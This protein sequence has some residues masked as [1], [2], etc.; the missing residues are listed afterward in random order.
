MSDEKKDLMD[1]AHVG[2]LEMI[3]TSIASVGPTVSKGNLMRMALTTAKR[4]PEQAYETEEDFL[5]AAEAA[6]T[7]LAPV[8][9]PAKHY[10]DGI[11]GLPACPF[12]KSIKNYMALVGALPATYKE[13][14]D[15]YNKPGRVADKLHVG[16][17][18]G[19]SPFCAVHQPLRSAIGDRMTIG[20]KKVAIYQL[21]CKT[22]GGF[23]GYADRWLEETGVDK[24]VVSDILDENMCCYCVRT[25]D[26]E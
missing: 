10:H 18:A 1:V 15:E 23:K 9:G 2:F 7:P 13:V 14:T 22:G 25:V 11:F 19:V 17:G 5:A 26:D 6:T 4:I 16:N 8:E 21:G 24:E 3:E 20:G 12:G